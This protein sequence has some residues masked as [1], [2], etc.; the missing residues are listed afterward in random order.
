MKSMFYLYLNQA[1]F[2]ISPISM[3]KN[4]IVVKLLFLFLLAMFL[5]FI[6][7]LIHKKNVIIFKKELDKKNILVIDN[8]KRN[9]RCLV[10]E[11]RGKSRKQESC[12]SLG[13][14]NELIFPYYKMMVLPSLWTKQ[15]FN[16]IL[17]L[18]LGGGVL[19]E[20]YAKSFPEALIDSVEIDSDIISIAQEYFGLKRTDNHQIHHTD[21]KTF[22]KNKLSEGE[23]Y[24]LIIV[25]AF[26]NNYIPKE[27]QAKSF[28]QSLQSL[29]SSTGL[30]AINMFYTH[31]DY[32]EHLNTF[33]S[34]FSS[35]TRTVYPGSANTIVFGFQNK[36]DY[37][38]NEI[39]L[40]KS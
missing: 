35:T 27:L 23:A 40:S 1:S 14:Q 16:K 19:S 7:Y 2:H 17:I 37:N 13:N 38:L 4:I 21:A 9:T 8:Y 34:I 26:D 29:L 12:I 30:V 28:I 31:E 32:P 20:Y 39:A 24:D 11:S 5:I 3:F 22:I 6:N 18:G 15:K 33:K 10:F 36:D 25:D